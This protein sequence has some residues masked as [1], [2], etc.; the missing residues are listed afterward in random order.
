MY[1][2][3]EELCLPQSTSNGESMSEFM[4]NFVWVCL[5]LQF[6]ESHYEL[7]YGWLTGHIMKNI[8]SIEMQ[9]DYFERMDNFLWHLCQ[10]LA[11]EKLVPQ[12]HIIYTIQWFDTN[13]F[14][15][16]KT[17]T[18]TTETVNDSNSNEF[19]RADNELRSKFHLLVQFFDEEMNKFSFDW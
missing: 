16:G 2:S 1:T 7:M 8:L 10:T 9:F 14:D 15:K 12:L 6:S 19:Q 13:I 11:T 4:S 18:T 17:A 5:C 3:S